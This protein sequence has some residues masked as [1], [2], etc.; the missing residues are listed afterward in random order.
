M[1]GFL[2]GAYPEAKAVLDPIEYLQIYADMVNVPSKVTRSPEAIKAIMEQQ[3]QQAQ[4]AQA[5]AQAQAAAQGAETLSK[6]Q[7]GTGNALDA[8]MGQ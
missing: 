1:T 3:A 7:L 2:A 4:E 5:M 6:T 8:L